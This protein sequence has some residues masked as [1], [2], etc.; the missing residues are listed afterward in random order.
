VEGYS[1]HLGTRKLFGKTVRFCFNLRLQP[2]MPAEP[3]AAP[4]IED[5][6]GCRAEFLALD[7]WIRGGIVP[8]CTVE[9][10]PETLPILMITTWL[11]FPER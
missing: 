8:V 3:I 11:Y 1:G 9:A 10:K 4:C 6:Q 7:M 5:S 2:V